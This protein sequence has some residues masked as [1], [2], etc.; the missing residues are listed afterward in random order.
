MGLF[1]AIGNVVGSVFGGGG[2]DAEA[3][4]EVVIENNT[5]PIINIEFDELGDALLEFGDDF[6]EN[7]SG[8]LD[9][10]TATIGFVGV[11]GV[12]TYALLRR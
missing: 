9:R 1:S 2:N 5:S 8:G 10:F 4:N 12:I 3:N 6:G 11:V 7:L